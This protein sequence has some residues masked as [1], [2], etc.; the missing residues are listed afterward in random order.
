MEQRRSNT[1]IARRGF[2]P[3]LR[4]GEME[5]PGPGPVSRVVDL[6]T[7]ERNGELRGLSMADCGKGLER[8]CYQLH[9]S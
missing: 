7:E 2:I 3:G 1:I 6:R 9:T 8:M 5:C 4:V